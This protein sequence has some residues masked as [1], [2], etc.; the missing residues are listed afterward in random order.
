MLLLIPYLFPEQAFIQRALGDLRL[1]ALETLLARGARATCS[2]EGVEAALCGE[3]GIPRQSDY[4]I[5]PITLEAD[6]GAAGT[7]YWLR[8]DPVH[9][10]VMRDRL[11]LAD[12]GVLEISRN[13]AEALAQSIA[14]HFGAA[15]SPHPLHPERWYVRFSAAPQLLT[16]PVSSA[17]GRD[18]NPLLPQ[19]EDARTFRTLLNELQ[20]LLFAHPVNQAREARGELP[21]NSLWLWGGGHKPAADSVGMPLYT[22]DAGARALGSFCHAKL[23]TL[24]S[25]MEPKL[26]QRHGAILL[27][28]LVSA[29]QYGDAYGWREA[30]RALERDWFAPLRQSL[31]RIAPAGVRLT[32]PV[33][34]TSLLLQRADAWKFW[35]RPRP[36]P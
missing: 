16:T 31:G 3:L 19:G 21:I 27:D 23:H 14:Q 11:M 1:P 15:F 26:L 25:H 20:M 4:P 36:L 2:A 5:A 30:I 33:N 6:G 24:P 10:R 8:A 7:D 9:L 35:L 22:Q 28:Q 32:D 18:I 12:S 29:G 34:G 13:E 17:V